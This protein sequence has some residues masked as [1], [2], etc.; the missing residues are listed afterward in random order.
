MGGSLPAGHPCR[1][2]LPHQL[3]PSSA[4]HSCTTA[5][6]AAGLS[7]RSFHDTVAARR[8]GGF[9]R[10]AVRLIRCFADLLS[11][12]SARRDCR[13]YFPASADDHPD[14]DGDRAQKPPPAAS[15]RTTTK[16][17]EI[18]K[19]PESLIAQKWRA[20]RGRA[21]WEQAARLP[22][23]HNQLTCRAHEAQAGRSINIQKKSGQRPASQAAAYFSG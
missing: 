12:T 18:I 17:D 4:P 21:T 11:A 16:L 15:S 14:R 1:R 3:T 5:C 6:A 8:S 19:Y 9:G 13:L 2:D 10:A 7:I 23:A 22:L 20:P